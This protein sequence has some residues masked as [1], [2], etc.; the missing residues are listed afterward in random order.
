MPASQTTLT[1]DTPD[2]PMET[3]EALPKSRALGAVSVIQEAFGIGEH[4][5]EA[6]HGFHCDERPSYNEPAAKDGWARTFGWFR[7]NLTPS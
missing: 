4:I 5:R 6:E 1:L 7:E 3:Y 2:G